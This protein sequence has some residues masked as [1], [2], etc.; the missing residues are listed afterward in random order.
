MNAVSSVPPDGLVL[1]LRQYGALTGTH[2]GGVNDILL[3]FVSGSASSTSFQSGA[4]NRNI[5][6]S[7][8]PAPWAG[9][10]ARNFTF[11]RVI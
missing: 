4:Q 11:C 5:S 2:I 6:L 1:C 8:L 7:I 9:T 10:K 3:P